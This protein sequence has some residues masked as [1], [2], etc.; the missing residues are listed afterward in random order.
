MLKLK[1]GGEGQLGYKDVEVH[2]SNIVV[3]LHCEYDV[4][5]MLNFDF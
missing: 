3:W 2:T 1:W 4:Y 5:A